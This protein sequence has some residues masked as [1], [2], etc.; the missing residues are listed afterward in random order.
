MNEKYR[1]IE[2]EKINDFEGVGLYLEHIKTR[3]KI[4][5][6]T[7]SDENKVFNITFRTPPSDNTGLPHILE[8]SVL[9]GSKKYPVKD[10]FVELAKGSLNTF[11]NAM[12]YPDKT[13][14]P[15]AST[16][17]KDFSNLVDIYLDAVFNPKIYEREEIFRQEGWHYL[18]NKNEDEL[19]YNGVVYNEMKGVYSSPEGVLERS[20]QKTLYKDTPYFF[21]S[22]GEP[23]EITKLT[24]QD[25]LDFHK[26][27]YHPSNSYI[28]LYGDLD[29]EKYLDKIDKEYLSNYEFK[30]IESKISIQEPYIREV[31]EEV[32]FAVLENT[33]DNNYY[34][35]SKVIGRYDNLIL[36]SAMELID[37][38]VFS[39]EGSPVKEVLLKSDITKDVSCS[40]ELDINLPYYCIIGKKCQ[41]GKE[42]EFKSIINNTLKDVI[43]NGINKDSIR[44]AINQIRFKIKEADYLTT[45]RGLIYSLTILR[46]MLYSDKRPFEVFNQLDILN[47]LE[48]KIGSDYYEKILEEYFLNNS[49]GALITGKPI[50]NLNEKN[51]DIIQK[52]LSRKKILLNKNNK[53]C[54][55]IEDSKN[56]LEYQRKEDDLDDIKKIPILKRE[57]IREKILPLN[58]KLYKWNNGTLIGHIINT[59]GISYVDCLFDVSDFTEDEIQIA[60]TLMQILGKVNTKKYTYNDISNLFNLY[61]GDNNFSL[62]GI[63]EINNNKTKV[64]VDIKFSFLDD[65]KNKAIELMHEVINNS[66]IYDKKRIMEIIASEKEQ[67]QSLINYSGH[68]TAAKRARSTID[69]YGKF[70]ELISGISYYKYLDSIYKKINEEDYFDKFSVKLEKIKNKIFVKRN[71]ILSLTVS[72]EEMIEKIRYS[73]D[74]WIDKLESYVFANDYLDLKIEN[75]VKEGIIIPSRV[76]YVARAGKFNS[77]NYN[78]C[79]E[80]LSTLMN[81]EYLWQKIRVEG[82]AYGCFGRF[83][84]SGIGIFSSYRDPHIKRTDDIY[85]SVSDYLSRVSISEDLFDKYIIGTFSKIDSPLN[86][87][88]SGL[89]SLSAF[90]AGIDETIMQS[91]RD[92]ILNAKLE[93]IRQLSL[94]VNNII[95]NSAVCVIGSKEKIEENKDYF[96]NIEVII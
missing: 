54:K 18:I 5:I 25:F 15:V 42:E 10:P 32:P 53:L 39:S 28:Y 58:N 90:L 88:Q 11:L 37:Y 65:N 36:N 96:D 76:N 89:R 7:N 31:K 23:D 63:E 47:E 70:T 57:D 24:Y 22:G 27:Y 77:K 52:E 12:T 86:A 46:K 73:I 62:T 55:I 95:E 33:P 38:A 84:Y 35:Y 64:Y 67:M 2:K 68:A 83:T 40:L 17:D 87:R 8:H 41:N 50:L 4:I 14:Y 85:K 82:G 74:N 30:K 81:Y 49:H 13:T 44:A 51:N 56:L 91:H 60:Y 6:I 78:G 72:N 75:K 66:I 3:A 19:K 92:D 45:P 48:E 94:E 9:C 29:Y 61:T 80:I 34:V 79:F 16:N 20:V 26:K 43:K 59:R 93:N 1:L 69:M 21:D 71:I